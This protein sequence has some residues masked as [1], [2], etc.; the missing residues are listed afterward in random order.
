MKKIIT[1]LTF[2]TI[3]IFGA[4]SKDDNQNTSE[5][6]KLVGRWIA[7]APTNGNDPYIEGSEY[8]FK[9]D[10]SFTGLYIELNY[11]G[12]NTVV[13]RDKLP[14]SGTYSISEDGKWLTIIEKGD[15]PDR[16]YIR[17]VT[18][19]K[20]QLS[21]LPSSQTVITYNKQ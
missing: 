10:G 21:E 19:H 14:Y 15:D 13:G 11:D 16:Y 7:E 9:S 5:T 18:D 17:Q 20:L 8:T 2:L 4:C 12:D 6:N 1:F 3:V